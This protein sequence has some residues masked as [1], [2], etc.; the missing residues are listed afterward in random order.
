MFKFAVYAST[1]G[2]NFRTVALTNYLDMARFIR[3]HAAEALDP[4]GRRNL[5][6]KLEE[7]PIADYLIAPRI[8]DRE[9][10]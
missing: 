5:T 3:D 1:D 10:E 7:R 9:V 6:V 8:E 4:A 2:K